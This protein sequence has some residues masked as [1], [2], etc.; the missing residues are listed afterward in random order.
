MG[1]RYDAPEKKNGEGGKGGQIGGGGNRGVGESSMSETFGGAPM[2]NE[3]KT[4]PGAPMRKTDLP[5]KITA[6]SGGGTNE[7]EVDNG[8]GM[9][10][11]SGKNVAQDNL[12]S[13]CDILV[14]PGPQKGRAVCLA[15]KGAQR[16]EDGGGSTDQKK[17]NKPADGLSEVKQNGS[18]DSG[19][20][21]PLRKVPAV[22]TSSTAKEMTVALEADNVARQPEQSR[23]SQTSSDSQ[24]AVKVPQSKPIFGAHVKE[25]TESKPYPWRQEAGVYGGVLG[26]AKFFGTVVQKD[27]VLFEVMLHKQ[28]ARLVPEEEQRM[29]RYEKAGTFGKCD[30]ASLD[31][32]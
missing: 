2:Q 14:G 28:T 29:R 27:L 12:V 11:V 18:I 19:V 24:G 25:T 23:E 5:Q 16:G 4:A 9:E 32:R 1:V 10:T 17:E 7:Q 8:K 20:K 21:G 15:N 30:Y 13:C 3:T 22:C 26:D 31:P 6:A